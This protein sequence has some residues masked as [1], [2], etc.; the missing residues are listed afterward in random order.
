MELYRGCWFNRTAS[1]QPVEKPVIAVDWE[2]TTVDRLR[3]AGDGPGAFWRESLVSA[4]VALLMILAMVLIAVFMI[5]LEQ[6]TDKR[7]DR[8]FEQELSAWRVR[9]QSRHSRRGA[10][11]PSRSGVT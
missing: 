7:R 3:L 2:L 9:L 6:V 1:K 4:T 8:E 10:K 11:G 5:V